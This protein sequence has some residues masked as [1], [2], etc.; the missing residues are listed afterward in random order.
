MQ[1][2]FRMGRLIKAHPSVHNVEPKRARL[3]PLERFCS[4]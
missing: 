4:H 2:S 1:P 3:Q